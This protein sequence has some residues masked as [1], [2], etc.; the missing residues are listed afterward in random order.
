MD[1]EKIMQINRSI[2]ISRK[3]FCNYKSR[4]DGGLDVCLS[5][6]KKEIQ[7]R[8]S[9]KKAP[10]IISWINNQRDLKREIQEYKKML[11]PVYNHNINRIEPDLVR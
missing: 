6:N 3:A 1:L 8:V 4:E 5:Y 2:V 9:C 7:V 10:T 11:I